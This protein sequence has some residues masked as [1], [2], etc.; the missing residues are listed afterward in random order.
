MNKYK[1]LFSFIVPSVI[2]FSLWSD[3]LFAFSTLFF[4]FAF[5][6]VL[7]LFT[8]TS[9]YNMTAEEETLAK[10]SFFYDGLIYLY[11]PIQFGL[12]FFFLVE[13]AS[14]T[15]LNFVVLGH[16]ITMGLACGIF[17][18]NVAHELG[19]RAT[20]YERFFS[21]SLLMTSLYMH[22]FIEHNYGHHQ[23]VSTD[24]DAASARKGESIYAFY[25][26]SIYTGWLSAWRIEANLLNRK[27]K[28]V[29][30]IHNQMILFTLIQI[31]F[32]TTIYFLFGLFA[33]I[34]FIAA[35]CLGI[36]LLETVNYIE[37]Y[38]LRRKTK[39]NGDYE[40]T[41]PAH[42]WNS[43]HLIGRILLFELSRH[44]DHHFISSRKYQILRHFDESPQMPTG[45]PGMMLL[46]LVPP[47][48]FKFIHKRIEDYK[49]KCI[50]SHLG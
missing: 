18:I 34:G 9:T 21:K 37:H 42:S 23:N 36:L 38:G 12:L 1:Y 3:N 39:G 14:A 25:M 15:E 17:G 5:I 45:Y 47:I 29:I 50:F 35:A 24:C 22:F 11:V 16:I 33:L 7:E 6:P 13:L 32:L 28:K 4:L 19:H 2:F 49:M 26:R 46:S 8:E 31:G 27:N 41:M 48:W 44:S 10:S 20:W 43:N 40:R 30:F